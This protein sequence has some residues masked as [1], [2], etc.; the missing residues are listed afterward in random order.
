MQK[1]F[2]HLLN[3][4]TESEVQAILD[5]DGLSSDPS[6]WTPYGDNESFFGVIENQQAHPQFYLK[7]MLPA[8]AME[9]PSISP[10]A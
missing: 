5:A 8:D 6:K 2:M 3:A 9:T 10:K 7:L 4:G 1:L